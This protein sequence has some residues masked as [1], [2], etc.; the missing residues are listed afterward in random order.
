MPAEP[1][2]PKSTVN[3]QFSRSHIGRASRLFTSDTK[4]Q[5][6]G[7]FLRREIW[8]WPLIAAV[9]FGGLGYWISGAVE[10]VMH[11]ERSEELSV[12]ADATVNALEIWIDDQRTIARLFAE[13]RELRPLVAELLAKL[14]LPVADR[15]LLQAPAQDALRQRLENRLTQSGFIGYFIVAPGGTILAADHDAPVGKPVDQYRKH[16]YD[17]ALSGEIVVSKPF[18]S[19]LLLDDENG[20][21]QQNLPTMIVIAPI[22]NDAGE[23][24]AALGIR[25]RPE[26][27]FSRILQVGRS[28]QSG[29]TLAFDS[30]GLLLSQSRFDEQLKQIGLLLDQPEAHSTLS[31]ELRD[32]GVN[33]V[34]GG[35]PQT[36]RPEQPLTRDVA[37]AVQGNSGSDADGFRDY[38]GVMK[39]AAWRW[40]PNHDF[41]VTTEMDVAEAFLPVYLLRR[42]FRALM[43]LLTLSAIA[44]FIAML[45]AARQQRSLQDVTIAAMQL[46]Q[47]ALEEKLGSGGMGTVYKARHALLRRPTAVKLLS[48]EQ[49]SESAVARF[50]REVQLTSSLSHPNTVSIFDY[51]RTPDGIFYY[52]MEYLDGM[53]LDDLVR[54][55]G[56]VPEARLVY[57]LKQACGALG[58]AHAAGLVHRDIKPANIFLTSRGGLFDFVKVLDFGLVKTLTAASEANLTNPNSVTGTPYYLSPEGV[59][60]PDQVDTRSDV[61]ALG[62]VAY[63]LLT[64]THVFEGGTVVEICLKH[65]RETPETPSQ[66][67]GQPVSPQL[68]SLIMKCLAKSPDERP[69]DASDLLRTLESLEV[70]GT[71][72]ETHAQLWWESHASQNLTSASTT[73]L[74]PNSLPTEDG[75]S[76][77]TR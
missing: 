21:L 36:R 33:M 41:G 73:V 75:A 2:P 67:R 74:L 70:T 62:A 30:N 38:R 49:M 65:T 24:L 10:A 7:R 68:E 51:G 76:D 48:L 47:Y 46:G 61:Y 40:L 28:G 18:R 54:R 50:E 6:T 23:P 27:Q 58:E 37:D 34:K 60:R 63:Y 20:Q 12:I 35:R 4:L 55:F 64:G 69:K 3:H 26:N 66:R 8:A 11:Q 45:Y 9:L 39:V 59:N 15:K 52:V 53:N 22:G 29:E 56:P 44:I 25:I 16:L 19:P 13:D 42:S 32:P 71:W 72:T 1:S 57:L 5:A 17:Q 31:V 14:D 43:A 77:Q